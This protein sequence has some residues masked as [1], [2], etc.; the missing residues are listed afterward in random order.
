M[1]SNDI[2]GALLQDF[3]VN[4][5][6]LGLVAIDDDRPVALWSHYHAERCVAQ[7]AIARERVRIA[8]WTLADVT[9]RGDARLVGRAEARLAAVRAELAEWERRRDL[10]EAARRIDSYAPRQS[11]FAA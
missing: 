8:E 4:D 1:S 10:L 9:P 2:D 6:I 3:S 5:G 7:L 11:P